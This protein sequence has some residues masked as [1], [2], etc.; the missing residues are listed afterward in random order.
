[1]CWWENTDKNFQHTSYDFLTCYAERCSYFIMDEYWTNLG[2]EYTLTAPLLRKK[3]NE[4]R[5]TEPVPKKQTTDTR[6][7]H[8]RTT[9]KNCSH[10]NFNVTNEQTSPWRKLLIKQQRT[11]VDCYQKYFSSWLVKFVHATRTKA[12][13]CS[14]VAREQMRKCT[15]FPSMPN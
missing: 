8:D 5:N 6:V 14:D 4:D 9:N 7:H 15:Q 13:N 10:R 11:V 3:T 1:M 12:A 2:I